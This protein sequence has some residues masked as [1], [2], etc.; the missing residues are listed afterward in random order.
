MYSRQNLVAGVRLGEERN[1]ELSQ[2]V[3]RQYLGRVT[4]R[5]QDALIGPLLPHLVGELDSV[6]TRHNNIDHDEIDACPDRVHGIEGL[7]T[8]LRFEHA[9][10]RFTEDTVCDPSGIALVIHNKDRGGGTGKRGGQL[11]SKLRVPQYR[12]GY[13]C[14]I[15]PLARSGSQPAILGADR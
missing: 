6:H 11:D 13:D 12:T 2:A 14:R 5:E 8:V 4:G 15:V 3:L 7:F 9:V 10:A 1:V